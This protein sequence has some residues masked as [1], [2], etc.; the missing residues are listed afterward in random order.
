M[1]NVLVDLQA[2]PGVERAAIAN[3]HLL[4]GGWSTTTL[5][6]QGAD[7]IVTDR[8]LPRMRVG[9]G[10]FAA[11][12]VPIV[13]GRDF[14]ERDVRAPGAKPT[15][16]RTAIVN[17]SFARR[18]FA[19]RSPVGARIG[20]GAR[21]DTPTNIEIIGVVRDFSMRDLRDDDRERVFFQF[22]D[23]NSA[24]GTFYVKT[25]GSADAILP[26]IRDVVDRL[27]PSLAILEART[28]DEQV[29]RSLRTERMLAALSSGFGLIALMLSVVGLYGLMSF[30]V[31]RR[32]PE[33][34][35]R[36]ALGA[37]RRSAVWLIV[38]DAS[39]VIAT[40][41]AVGLSS[42]SGLSRLVEAQLFGVGAVHAP[43][44]AAASALLASVA[45][46]AALVPAWRAASVNPTE[47]LRAE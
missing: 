31:T 14:D 11:L 32:T 16:Y 35:L 46:A 5:T 13:A 21:P 12:G 26:S 18:Y 7:R 8:E 4:S 22:W 1:R 27:D 33:I 45:L 20:L 24:D 17:E 36:L 3:S 25:R 44:I 38:R 39:I 9:P 47:S 15:P 29:D 10:F 37:T 28:I 41:T 19:D 43:T 42:V 30:V 6:I 23:Q 2:V 40:A 34:G